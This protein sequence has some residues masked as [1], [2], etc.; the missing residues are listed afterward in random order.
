MRDMLEG[1]EGRAAVLREYG[2]GAPPDCL[3]LTARVIQLCERC[4]KLMS[5]SM[6]RVTG[7]S[8][9]TAIRSYSALKTIYILHPRHWWRSIRLLFNLDSHTARYAV[10]TSLAAALGMAIY[11]WTGI[12]HGY[13]LPFTVIIVMQPY[14]VATFRKAV[15]RTIGT[16][17]GGMAGG[18][19]LLLP[20]GLHL[21]EVLLFLSAMAMIYFFRAQYR[22]S[23]FFITL[24]LVV[25]FSLSQVLDTRIIL[26]RAGLTILG[27]TIAVG[28]GFALLPAWDKRWLPRY[29]ARALERNWAYFRLTFLSGEMTA[30]HWTR[31]KR[32]AEVSNGNAFD[33]FNRAIQEPGGLQREYSRYYQLITHNV[34]VTRELNNIHLE[35]DAKGDSSGGNQDAAALVE[36]CTQT[37]LDVLTLGQRL[38]GKTFPEELLARP[39]AQTP[40]LN[41]AQKLYLERLSTEL[42]MLKETLTGLLAQSDVPAEP[43]TAETAM[44][45]QRPI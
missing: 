39:A 21:K 8:E 27:A 42:R 10:R 35:E 37:F 1:I 28:A 19:L 7:L 17:A 40:R 38:S 45:V 33:S 23:A 26:E 36:Q 24:N 9:R 25:L 44:S 31:Y 30:A 14:F 3:R 20:A 5:H 13:W 22:I 4:A 32:Q 41:P 12:D 6:E 11:K 43:A 34:R 29:M 18:L 15:D 16:V 2:V